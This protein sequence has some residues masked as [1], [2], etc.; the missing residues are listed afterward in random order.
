MTFQSPTSRGG[1]CNWRATKAQSKAA[2]GVSIPYFAGRPLQ[3]P[4]GPAPATLPTDSFNPLLRGA[5]FAT[6]ARKHAALLMHYGFNPLLRGAAFATIRNAEVSASELDCFNPLLR[7]AAFATSVPS[8]SLPMDEDVSIPYFAGRPLQRHFEL[9]RPFLASPHEALRRR[10]VVGPN[11]A[12]G[13]H[14]PLLEAGF[15]VDHPVGALDSGKVTAVMRMGA[16]VSHTEA[17]IMAARRWV[18]WCR[19]V[20]DWRLRELGPAM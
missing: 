19:T 5:A 8:V 3:Q 18:V 13:G 10:F 1:L 15:E 2:R 4:P 14:P 11:W 12:G 6:E 7:G 16:T 9:G 20:I 17:M